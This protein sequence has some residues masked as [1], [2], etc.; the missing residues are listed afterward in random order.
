MVFVFS[1]GLKNL[2]YYDVMELLVIEDWS[3][4]IVKYRGVNFYVY[5]CFEKCSINLN[6][7][8]VF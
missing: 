6:K 1:V 7:I 2:N 5:V 4:N 8:L 3:F